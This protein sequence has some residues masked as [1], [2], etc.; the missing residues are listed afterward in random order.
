MPSTATPSTGAPSTATRPAAPPFTPPKGSI[1]QLVGRMNF[2]KQDIGVYFTYTP[3]KIFRGDVAQPLL[4]IKQGEGVE[5]RKIKIVL[6]GSLHVP[7]DMNVIVWHGGGS[8]SGGVHQL[9]IDNNLLGSIGDDRTK[10][11]TYTVPLTKGEHVINWELTGGELGNSIA[12]FTRPK[13]CRRCR[14]TRRPT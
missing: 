11:V 10:N 14:Y 5:Q 7:A 1:P 9:K 13:I 4:G 8:A 2:D 3:G 6:M 12:A